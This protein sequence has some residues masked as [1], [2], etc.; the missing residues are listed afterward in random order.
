ME[1]WQQFDQLPAAQARTRLQACCG[2][3]RWVDRMMRRRP[4]GSTETLLNAAREEWFALDE[5]DWLEAFRHHPKIGDRSAWQS[6]F[7]ET[8]T[9]SM[10]EQHG[11]ADAQDDILDALAEGNRAYEE[12]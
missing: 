9:L 3:S 12:K 11:V 2:A 1:P 7:P 8:A 5:A 4:F 10:Q 6:R